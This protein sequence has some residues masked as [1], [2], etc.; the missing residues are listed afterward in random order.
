MQQPL[1]QG[2]LAENPSPSSSASTAAPSPTFQ[3][4]GRRFESDYE[5]LGAVLGTGASGSVRQARCRRT[6]RHAAVKIFRVKELSAKML[7]NLEWEIDVHSAMKHPGIV[8]IQAV[9][10]TDDTVHIV[11]EQL[12][13]GELFDRLLEQGRFEEEEAAKVVAQ[14][15]RAVSYLHAQNVMHRDIKPENVMFC[16]KEGKEVKLIDFGFAT[17]FERHTPV[18]QRCGTMQYVAPEVLM[19]QGYDEK[20]DLWSLGC[21]CYTLLTMKALYAGDDAEVRRKNRLGLVDWSRS[22]KT[23]SPEAQDFV[24]C[25]LR[26]DPASR[27]SAERALRHPWLKQHAREEVAADCRKLAV[28][29]PEEVL[30]PSP[31]QTII[32]SE[33]VQPE[34]A[35]GHA[36]EPCFAGVSKLIG[37]SG[38]D[39]EARALVISVAQRFVTIA[40]DSVAS[41]AK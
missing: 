8:D 7:L 32:A 26:V 38:W 33:V 35:C 6:G 15:L 3:P 1:K 14:L 20:A 30:K 9:Y 28:Q 27:F 2:A 17:R 19:G 21:V 11:M 31:Q 40:L 41:V 29:E 4:G 39:V 36:S 34:L 24:R 18:S 10:E 37:P 12:C 22:F 13:G 23:L 5:L 25:L 16:S